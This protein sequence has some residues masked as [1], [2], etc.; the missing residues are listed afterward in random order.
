MRAVAQWQSGRGNAP[1]DTWR[2][3]GRGPEETSQLPTER[4]RVQVRVLPARRNI[5]SYREEVQVKRIIELE[6]VPCGYSGEHPLYRAVGFKTLVFD[7]EGLDKLQ[8]YKAP[9]TEKE[10]WEMRH[11]SYNAG[12]AKALDEKT[13]DLR[14]IERDFQKRLKS[15]TGA[16]YAK[17]VEVGMKRAAPVPE[18]CSVFN[19]AALYPGDE[20]ILGKTIHH[21]LGAKIGSKAIVSHVAYSEDGELRATVFSGRFVLDLMEGEFKKTG[22]AFPEVIKA[23]EQLEEIPE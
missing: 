6:N 4:P 8:E 16:A 18:D 13:E 21:V 10:L 5:N 11:E 22:R 14:N 17:G 20:V 2:S 23:I 12:Y 1:G 7:R 15:E 3:R 9:Y 19:T